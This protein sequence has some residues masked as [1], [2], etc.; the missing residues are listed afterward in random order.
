MSGFKWLKR[1]ELKLLGFKHTA[2]FKFTT[3]TT[4]RDGAAAGT[5]PDAD[6]AIGDGGAS[7]PLTMGGVGCGSRD[8]HY[9]HSALVHKSPRV[10][11]TT[12][13]PLHGV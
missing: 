10:F 6:Y 11:Y 13:H 2:P 1:S 3:R 12:Q 9:L 4:L 5:F 7:A 8:V